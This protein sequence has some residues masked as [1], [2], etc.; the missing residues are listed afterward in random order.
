[1]QD[2]NSTTLLPRTI[3]NQNSRAAYFA[4]SCVVQ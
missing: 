4:A 2:L 1:L 3:L